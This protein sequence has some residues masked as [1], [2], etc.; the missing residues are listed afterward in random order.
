MK[1]DAKYYYST[2][3]FFMSIWSKYIVISGELVT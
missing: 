3:K 2:L 1:T